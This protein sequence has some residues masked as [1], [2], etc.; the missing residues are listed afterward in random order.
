M[1]NVYK[2]NDILKNV[3]YAFH[4]DRVIPAYVYVAP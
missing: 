1:S 3:K 4:G 2:C